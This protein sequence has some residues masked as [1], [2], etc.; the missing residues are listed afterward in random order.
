MLSVKQG[1]IKYYFFFFFFFFESLVWLELNP[2]RPTLLGQCRD[3]VE[4]APCQNKSKN[5]L[6]NDNT[7]KCKYEH[8]INVI[9]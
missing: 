1:G 5:L 8:T 4:K 9:P 6:R 7:K 3:H 2:G